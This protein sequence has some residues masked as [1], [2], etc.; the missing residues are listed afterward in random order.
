MSCCV[1]DCCVVDCGFCC[2]MDFCSDTG[3]GY[4]PDANNH[5]VEHSTKISNELAEMKERAA[6]E[7]GKI[8]EEAF[9]SINVYLQQFIEH[10]KTINATIYG[11]K[12]LNIKIDIIEKE[13]AKL[14]DEVTNFVGICID[15]RLV[16]TDRE[17]SI[18]LEERDDKKRSRNFDDFYKRVHKQAVLDLS[19]KIEEVIARQFVL[20][21]VEIRNRLKEVDGA[22]QEALASYTEA[23]RMKKEKDVSFGGKQV[24]C[25][26][27]VTLADIMLDELNAIME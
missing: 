24:E 25:M 12:K 13:I 19:K 6:T 7:G 1:G 26:Y 4:H 15:D 8:G 5:T 18:I 10:L 16:L 14:R 27:V 9:E 21:D 2:V 11:G 17:L 22:M 20:V 23:E 3:C